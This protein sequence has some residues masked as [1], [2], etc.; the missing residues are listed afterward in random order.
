MAARHGA[1]LEVGDRVQIF[2][3]EMNTQYNGLFGRIVKQGDDLATVLLETPLCRFTKIEFRCSNLKLVPTDAEAEAEAGEAAEEAEEAEEA[4]TSGARF[5]IGDRVQ[6]SDLQMK[7]QYNGHFGKI[8]NILQ[9]REIAMVRL[10]QPL[11]KSKIQLRCGN[12][13]LVPAEAEAEAE[14]TEA[15]EAEERGGEEEAVVVEAVVVEEAEEEERATTGASPSYSLVTF[16]PKAST[17]RMM[18]DLL[19][20]DIPINQSEIN[21]TD[22]MTA[23]KCIS[24]I[25]QERHIS[26][27]SLVTLKSEFMKVRNKMHPDKWSAERDL[28]TRAF[29]VVSRLADNLADKIKE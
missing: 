15:E 6:V 19:T 27:P 29:Q 25:A 16:D 11:N 13:K 4:N 20:L 2:D 28:A 21:L 26:I 23:Y 5:E 3:L 7:P 9:S 22:I 8:V 14:A 18:E 17:Q 24:G 10:E 1:R 12:L